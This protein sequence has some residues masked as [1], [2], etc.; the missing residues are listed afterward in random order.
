MVCGNNVYQ[1]YGVHDKEDTENQWGL[2]FCGCIFHT[3]ERKYEEATVE[4]IEKE[5]KEKQVKGY[6]DR[7]EHYCRLYLPIIEES[8]YGRQALI[9]GNN[10][11][12]LDAKL[13]DRGWITQTINISKFRDYDFTV[14]KYYLII[15]NSCLQETDYPIQ[16][17][18]KAYNLLFPSGMVL[19]TTADTETMKLLCN[20]MEWYRWDINKYRLFFSRTQLEKTL[21][22]IGFEIILHRVNLDDRLFE[23]NEVHIIASKGLDDHLYQPIKEE[24]KK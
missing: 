7:L 10:V 17:L 23:S 5:L 22:R 3:Y 11:P 14:N 21:K 13:R 6:E 4:S 19:I 1:S 2:C 20:P 15:L 9:I 18:Q 16:M 12:K 24:V 8:T